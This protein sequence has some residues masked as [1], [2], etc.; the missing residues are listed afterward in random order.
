MDGSDGGFQ[1][2]YNYSGY[3]AAH[4]AGSD[5]DAARVF[6]AE[7]CDSGDAARAE[8]AAREVVALSRP[9]EIFSAIAHDACSAFSDASSSSVGVTISQAREWAARMTT[10]V[11]QSKL[12]LEGPSDEEPPAPKPFSEDPA[13]VAAV[14]FDSRF[15][16]PR[17]GT[18]YP[19][20]VPV[21]NEQGLLSRISARGLYRYHCNHCAACRAAEAAGSFDAGCYIHT[22]CSLLADGAWLSW[23]DGLE[24]VE[25]F[26]DSGG[27]CRFSDVSGDEVE[28]EKAKFLLEELET[29]RK[30][31]S[32][33]ILTPEQV[34][35]P[36]QC[37]YISQIDAAPRQVPVLSEMAAKLAT[38]TP[39]G[40]DVKAIS[41]L[42]EADARTCGG[43]PILQV[44]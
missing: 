15:V 32:I 21:D 25:P 4:S 28:Q 29:W 20:G 14:L 17:R 11:A 36:D 1:Y 3:A 43:G 26:D 18:E 40:Y 22:Y 9:S 12:R 30:R 5:D 39:G 35:D 13:E 8:R 6:L 37:F 34:A 16:R 2:D 19:G 33:E 24:P 31:G 27:R 38:P 44:V 41:A 23:K 7:M 10:A 42:M